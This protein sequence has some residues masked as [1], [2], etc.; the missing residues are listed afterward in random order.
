MNIVSKIYKKIINKYKFKINLDK[1]KIKLK[2]LEDLFNY[3]GTDKG[4]KPLNPYSKLKNKKNFK[5]HNFSKFYEKHFRNL[6]R[7]KIN[8]L[9]IGVWEG[10]S[11]A[12]FYHYFKNAKFFSIDRNFKL[13]YF[14]KR[15]NFVYC[16]TTS[17]KDLSKFKSFL[18]QEKVNTFDIII[19]DGS[20][21][22]SNILKN[23]IF[24]FR[25]VKPGGIY[26]IEDYKHP[27][28]FSYLNDVKKHFFVD[29]VLLFLKNK[30]IF[31]SKILSRKE[32]TYL[33]NQIKN[34]FTYKGDCVVK[35]KN[36][37][38]IAFLFKKINK[39]S[40]SI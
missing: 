14:S 25:Y 9:E 22:L 20:H 3:F 32:I 26:V 30:K 15:I 39:N 37:S 17:S 1:Q 29:K 38:D 21:I 2:Q 18:K 34:I 19:D 16:D 7:K 8:I 12:S 13:K 4:S 24:F 28:Y 27:N 6:K 33:M 36:I 40:A 5:G 11:T 23:L 35:R 10:A 31:K